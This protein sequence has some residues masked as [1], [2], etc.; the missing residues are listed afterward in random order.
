MKMMTMTKQK[1]LLVNFLFIGLIFCG[2][3][4]KGKNSPEYDLINHIVCSLDENSLRKEFIGL[5]LYKYNSYKSLN[6]KN[7]ISA[8]KKVNFDLDSI[9]N[10]LQREQIEV[11]L[12]SKK[13]SE[14]EKKY[15]SRKNVLFPQNG[16]KDYVLK[17]KL[18]TISYPII[19]KGLNDHLYG[20]VIESE[21][22]EFDGFTNL[23]IYRKD[24]VT[25]KVI[26]EE[27]IGMS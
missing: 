25:W 19:S 13:S 15:L 9:F 1:E 3:Q 5:E 12:S 24:S 21:V 4:L 7:R 23:K 17:K 26:Y 10:E 6:P 14:I 8:F 22:F 18:Y 11:T 27:L 20:I 16:K 2:F